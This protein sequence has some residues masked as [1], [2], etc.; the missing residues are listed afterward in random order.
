MSTWKFDIDSENTESA[1]IKEKIKRLKRNPK[2]IPIL[3]NIYETEYSGTPMTLDSGPILEKPILLYDPVKKIVEKRKKSRWQSDS[4]PLN[5]QY[6]PGTQIDFVSFD[7]QNSRMG[8]STELSCPEGRRGR[9]I[10]NPKDF[11]EPG[12]PATLVEGMTNSL[13]IDAA[14]LSGKFKDSV[15]IN[16]DNYNSL[17]ELYNKIADQN[18]SNKT[19]QNSKDILKSVNSGS[20]NPDLLNSGKSSFWFPSSEVSDLP[21][22][23]AANDKSAM[24]ATALIGAA[25]TKV[26]SL[27]DQVSGAMTSDRASLSAQISS[28]KSGMSSQNLVDTNIPIP[29]ATPGSKAQTQIQVK[30]LGDQ[31]KTGMQKSVNEIS[32]ILTTAGKA[33]GQGISYIVKIFLSVLLNFRDKYNYFVITMSN[34]L[35]NNNATISEVKVFSSEILKFTTVLFTYIFVYNWYYLMFGMDEGQPRFK[36]DL[37]ENLMKP[38]PSI[39]TLFGP[40]LKPTEL[41]DWFLLDK[42]PEWMKAIN[43]KPVLFF[44]LAVVFFCLVLGNVQMQI[45][46]SF[47][48][49]LTFTTTAS[50][51]S[52]IMSILTMGFACYWIYQSEIWH[53]AAS[54]YGIGGIAALIGC[55][56]V[57]VL[58]LIYTMFF[59]V[60][61]AIFSLNTYIMIYSFFAIIIYREDG[62]VYAT[63]KKI[64]EAVSPTQS[65]LNG[66]TPDDEPEDIPGEHETILEKMARLLKKWGGWIVKMIEKYAKYANMYLVEL[67]MIMILLAGINTYTSQYGSVQFD[68]TDS[69]NVNNIGSPVNSAFKHLFTWLIIINTIIILFLGVRMWGKYYNLKQEAAEE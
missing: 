5:Q 63:I 40:S 16:N 62:G 47:L 3:E 31:L 66:T 65:D 54:I 69:Q 25:K 46:T 44:L 60:P 20:S 29:T 7:S 27:T 10:R 34:G 4:G 50:A 32:Y 6:P 30:G 11:L 57:S 15:M 43:S 9:A 23:K 61:L 39:F 42:I 56:I 21:K 36:L 64:Y 68:K 45:L 24:D 58:Y 28:L 35:T 55:L 38:Y 52:I 19:T 8:N 18:K 22:H 48:N 12:F 67:L 1:K 26:N 14:D 13:G 37:D 2:N 33:S 59:G 41:L 53:K 49:A 17:T 51:L